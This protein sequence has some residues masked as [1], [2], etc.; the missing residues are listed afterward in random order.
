MILQPDNCYQAL[1]AHDARFD[2]IFF[3]GVTSTG[4]YCRPVCR[5]KP[6]RRENCLFFRSAAA[7]ERAGY[8]PCL[9]CRPE[10]APGRGHMEA[11]SHLAA[12]ALRRIEEGALTEGSL[13]DLAAEFGVSD[14]HLR[15]VIQT[16]FGV[17]PVQFVQTQRL[18]LAKRLLTDTTLPITEVAFASGFASLRRF[19]TL[20]RERYR[21]NPSDLRKTRLAPPPQ[22]TLVCELAYRPPYDTASLFG[23]LGVRAVRGVETVEGER[24]RRT[25]ALGDMQGWFTVE[26]LPDKSALRVEM[27]AS[28]ARVLVPVLSRLRYLFDVNAD[29]AQIAVSLGTLAEARPGLRIPGAFDGFEMA[30][31][32]VLGQQV[33]VAAAATLMGRF[34]G[35][36]GAPMETPFPGLTHLTPTADRVARESPDALTALGILPARARSILALAQAVTEKRL[37]LVPGADPAPTMAHLLELPGVGEWTAQYIALRALAWPDA[38]PHTDLGIRKALGETNPRRVLAHAEAWRPWRGYAALHLWKSL[39]E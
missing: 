34:V 35:A 28:L 16:E 27:C 29:P 24:Y 36:F 20:F 38:F 39:E 26:S 10:L 2:G 11:A 30:I 14:R 33:S 31:R 21:L 4:I 7:A 12:V 32:A 1:L 37:R 8:R 5:V 19:N 25:A 22:S 13:E 23:F 15:R 9:R 18:L 3:V 17:S 6:P